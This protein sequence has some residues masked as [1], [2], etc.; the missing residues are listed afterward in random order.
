ME[1]PLCPHHPGSKVVRAGWYGESPHRRQRWLCRPSNG[2]DSHRFIELLPREEAERDHC[3]SC[4]TELEEWE[5]QNGAK[6]YLFQAQAIAHCLFLIAKGLSYRKAGEASRSI[7]RRPRSYKPRGGAYP[8]RKNYYSNESQIA[9]NW[10]D[11]YGPIVTAGELPA[12]WPDRIAVDSAQFH[13]KGWAVVRIGMTWNVLAAVGYDAADPNEVGRVVKLMPAP[14]HTI[15]SW[16]AFYDSL[17]G[18][19]ERVVADAEPAPRTAATNVFPRAGAAP[20]RLYYCED[21]LRRYAI[22]QLPRHIRT[23]PTHPLMI[24]IQKAFSGSNAWIAFENLALAEHAANAMPLFAR[25]MYA[26]GGIAK[27]QVASR[28]PGA[29]HATG[30]TEAVL[31]KIRE[32]LNK[33]ASTMTNIVRAQKLLDLFLLDFNGQVDEQAWVEKIRLELLRRHGWAGHQRPHDDP[34]G[35]WSLVS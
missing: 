20:P 15:P 33:R 17:G 5:G 18:S 28:P 3:V 23:D 31:H 29:P 19:P 6:R 8:Y 12:E 4:A 11:I 32:R 7:A 24:Q 30:A 22:T 21:H 35:T 34:K 13:Y 1:I 16:E 14:D 2:D 26:W 27:A 9:M 25:W 10:L